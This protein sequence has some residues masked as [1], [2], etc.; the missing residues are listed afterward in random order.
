[1]YQASQVVSRSLHYVCRVRE[2]ERDEK[3]AG[4]RRGSGGSGRVEGVLR[5]YRRES[6]GFRR[7]PS[8]ELSETRLRT[9]RKGGGLG[10]GEEGNEAEGSV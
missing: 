3:E 6:R 7:F 4:R 10:R 9:G 1:M 2:A 5:G 8:A